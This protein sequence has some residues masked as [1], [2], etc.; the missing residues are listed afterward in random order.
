MPARAYAR[1][2]LL[3]ADAAAFIA[4][5]HAEAAAAGAALRFFSSVMPFIFP[6]RC[7]CLTRPMPVCRLRFH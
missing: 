2:R 1:V 3:F 4:A 7:R 5:R 6:L